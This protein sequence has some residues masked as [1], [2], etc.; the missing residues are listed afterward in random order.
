MRVSL[1]KPQIY[2]VFIILF[3]ITEIIVPQK[4]KKNIATPLKQMPVYIESHIIPNGNKFRC[5]LTYKIK[6]GNLFF[7][8][9]EK[10]FVAEY[11]FSFE[12]FQKEKFVKRIFSN[13]KVT[14]DKY[15]NTLNNNAYSEGIVSFDITEGKYLI[16]P[17]ILLKNTDIEAKLLPFTISVDSTNIY[18]PYFIKNKI[19]LCKEGKF[20]LE[21]LQ[22]SIP[23]TEYKVN[24]LIP[25]Y[26]NNKAQNIKVLF[27]QDNRIIIEQKEFKHEI[28][29]TEPHICGNEIILSKF[30]N[31]SKTKFIK[32]ESINSKLYEGNVNIVIEIN[33]KKF[34]FPVSVIWDNKPITLSNTET[35]TEYLEIL[36]LSDVAD[37]ILN[38]PEDKRYNALFNYWK[39]FDDDTTTVFN[40]AL[41]EFYTRI[42]YVITHFNSVGKHDGIETDRGK[43]YVIYGKPDNVERKYSNVYN[44]MEIWEYKSIDKKI[45]FS[46]KTGTGNFKRIK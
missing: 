11:S 28:L 2:I 23:F 1:I 17:V 41:E 45:Y 20:V 13:K 40:P 6:F 43:M 38:F 44:I 35:A 36:G 10:K 3:L 15:N 42:D 19:P 32:I 9:A 22:N 21:N 7:I 33:E 30:N 8:K 5:V 46:D 25:L 14:T 34:S 16:K 4:R 39:K 27:I 29:N 12:V 26:N 24:M 18:Q 31:K 37:D